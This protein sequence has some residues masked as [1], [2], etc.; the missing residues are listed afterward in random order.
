[1]HDYLHDYDYLHRLDM[2]CNMKLLIYTQLLNASDNLTCPNYRQM[3]I[4]VNLVKS[5]IIR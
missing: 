3:N 5:S 2:L 1:M 4:F